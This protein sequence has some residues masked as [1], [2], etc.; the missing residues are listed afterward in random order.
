MK[1]IFLI[2]FF[3]SSIFAMSQRDILGTWEMSSLSDKRANV[4]FGLYNSFDESFTIEFREDG[5]VKYHGDEYESYYIFEINKFFVSKHKPENGRFLNAKAIDIYEVVKPLDRRDVNGKE[6]YEI[7][8]LQK[9]LSGIYVRKD[10]QKL[11][12]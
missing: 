8:I 1:I 7:H 9:A 2:I 5:I 11:C 4:S 3:I 6:C 10:N 12:R